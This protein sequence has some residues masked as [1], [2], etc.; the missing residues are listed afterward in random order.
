M[1]DKNKI[2]KQP[3]NDIEELRRR[4]DELEKENAR[5][6]K[7]EEGRK[8]QTE[9]Y[10][11]LFDSMTAI[12]WCIDRDGRVI[13]V[14]K[15]TADGRGLP[16]GD[17]IGKSLYDL[18]P[19]DE[20]SRLSAEN[21]EVMDFEKPKFGVIER[22]T[23]STGEK[24]WGKS[25]K[26]P[27][28]D[29]NGD[30]AGV[31]IFGQ[32]ITE[33]KRA[34]EELSAANE[35]WE[36][37]FDA[38]PDLIAILDSDFRIVHANRAMA[39]R[40]GLS[41][42][43]CVDKFCY[44]VVHGT[45]G[46]PSF[47]PHAQL[48]KDGQVHV[49][50]IC[51][52]RLG[53]EFTISTS[54]IFDSQGQMTG[55]VHVA[56]DITELK[57]TEEALRANQFRLTEAMAIAKVVHWEVDF[58]SS[59][60]VFNDPFYQLFQTT[61]E[62]EGGYRMAVD[63]YARRFVHPDDLERF[64][65][66]HKENMTKLDT[67]DLFQFEHKAVR[68]DG[69]VI[70][71]LSRTMILRDTSG[72]IAGVHGSNQD[73]TERKLAEES[74][75][76]IQMRLSE[77]MDIARLAYWEV[78][79]A[80]EIFTFNDAFYDLIGT[81]TEREGG[82]TM[83]AGKYLTKFVHPDDLPAVYRL[84]DELR[85]DPDP[86]RSADLETRFI[87]GD[88]EVRHMLVRMRIIG[89][90]A[91]KG[92]RLFG[93]NQDITVQKKTEEALRQSEQLHRMLA[94]NSSDMI[95]IQDPRTYRAIYV[96]PSVF[97]L[98]GYTQQE[99]MEMPWEARLTPDSITASKEHNTRALE[100]AAQ[101]R[102]IEDE[103][104][105]LE[106]PCK[107][108]SMVWTETIARGLYDA[109]GNLTAIHG[110]SRDITARKRAED[111]LRTSQ[112]HLSEAMD[113]ARV[114]YWEIDWATETFIF[115]DPFYAFLATNADREGGYQMP[116]SEYIERFVHPD[117]I[118]LVRRSV[119]GIRT[120]TESEFQIDIEHRIV[121]RDGVTRHIA[122]RERGFRDATGSIVRCHGANQDITDRKKT[123]MELA[124]VNRALR[125]L[126][127]SNQMLIHV[128]DESTLLNEVC[129]IAVEVGGYR[130][131]WVGFAEQDE[132][133]TIRPAAWA[134]VEAGYIESIKA[135]WADCD[136]GR[137]PGGVAIRTGQPCIVH[138][139]SQDPAFASWRDEANRRG[140]Q[141]VIALPLTHEDRTFGTLGI[142]ACEAGAFDAE[143][144]EI[145]KELAGDLA[146]GI[147]GLRARAARKRAEEEKAAL[148]SQLVQA[149]KM[150][151]IGQ[152]AGGVAHDFNNILTVITG[153]G[154]LIK[155]AVDKHEPAKEEYID[156][157][158]S[159]AEKAVNLTQSLL[160]F[161]RKQTINL[162]PHSLN[163]TVADTGKLL[164]RLLTEDI[165]LKIILSKEDLIIMADVTQ[166]D[167]ILINLAAN[168]RDAMPNGGFLSIRTEVA[169]L[170]DEFIKA[171]GYGVQGEYALISVLDTGIGMDKATKEHIFEPFFTTKEMGKGTGLG[172]A[173]VY[174]IVKQHNGYISV[175]SEPGHGT[176][177]F[178]YLPLVNSGRTDETLP[179]EKIKGGSETVLVVEDNE[180]VRKLTTEI[181]RAHGYTTF[182]AVDGEDAVKVF[183]ENQEKVDLILL[184]V[185]MPKKNGKEVYEEIKR[186][187]PDIRV[188]FTSGY[189]GDIILDKGIKGD[190][191]DLIS[192]PMS[193]NGLLKKVREVLDR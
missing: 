12:I 71:I 130:M 14:N 54:P 157:I 162:V 139:V 116:A 67:Q 21:R 129:R 132:A 158:L 46:P 106:N 90:S 82:Y 47:C 155:M 188:I 63:E 136:R 192:K 115:N 112:I 15:I 56:H 89:D 75:R 125:M 16:A 29:E 171:H 122:V 61:A 79:G 165:E 182:V 170:D 189:T 153:F 98:T 39:G 99:A 10:L 95:W 151:A 13:R 6:I 11:S 33:R 176:T 177:F 185:V 92:T 175:N 181:L 73:I 18:F 187:H 70:H 124:R 59:E 166:I 169:E 96:S 100:E 8:K 159:A 142:Y 103:V 152:L 146:F 149:Q 7:K 126:G 94:E 114:V 64:F 111:A 167:Q 178:V 183:M 174:G 161:G 117:D 190:T 193:P 133:K 36:H 77:A 43:E 134:G 87:L 109:S 60:L 173:T 120:S 179:S 86:G 76:T 80:T 105:I 45:E 2:I 66:N 51:E 123:E 168:A 97:R 31:L 74:L 108:G 27:Y 141:S 180:L 131:A 102:R 49:A 85:A 137:G 65:V 118:A 119:E 17:V 55:S 24:P 30:V 78:D 83:E 113:L 44:K 138:D 107:D 144:V 148:E 184:D 140:Y 52:A 42:G 160:A 186:I 57:R 34:E 28:Y 150:E 101:G 128:A 40:L 154:T 172:L 72:R 147:T 1:K 127:D 104:L 110:V 143:E 3:V 9:K 37:T 88:G 81:T 84:V 164:D 163:D 41:P 5:H 93:I 121:R 135:T 91:G 38:V 22:Y 4:I 35:R 23:L 191:V 20:A 58:E 48:L 25:D 62:Q 53:G 50:E 145:L 68:R 19:P 26:I 69:A 156:Q 32:S